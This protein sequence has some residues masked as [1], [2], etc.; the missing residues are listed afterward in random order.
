ME[1]GRLLRIVVNSFALVLL[2]I[3]AAVTFQ[4]NPA[5]SLVLALAAIDQFED[6]YTYV[7]NRRLF[8][9]W[10][11]PFDLLFEVVLFGVG[12]GMLVFSVVYYAYFETWFFRALIPLSLLI[13]YSSVEDVVMWLGGLKT[14]PTTVM[15]YVCSK[16]EVREEKR[17]V[18][19]RY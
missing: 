15:H 13:M 5:L 9:E 8:P 16:E 14:Q 7:Y 3:M 6:V 1:F 4:G 11:F 2:L 18:K 19:R 12:L 17:F 10:F